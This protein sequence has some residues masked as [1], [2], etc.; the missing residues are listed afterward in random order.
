VC[1]VEVKV[2]GEVARIIHK[3]RSS[4]KID[5]GFIRLEWFGQK[6]KKMEFNLLG[7]KNP[8]GGGG[9]EESATEG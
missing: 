1:D 7:R 9:G 8:K 2:D 4:L 3:K 5:F 6:G